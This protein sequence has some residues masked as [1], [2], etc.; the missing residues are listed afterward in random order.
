M[1]AKRRGLMGSRA[2]FTYLYIRGVREGNQGFTRRHSQRSNTTC[3]QAPKRLAN[4]DTKF[5][6]LRATL[7]SYQKIIGLRALH[8]NLGDKA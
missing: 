2:I 4:R 8:V 1:M 5:E 3:V 7:A 6:S